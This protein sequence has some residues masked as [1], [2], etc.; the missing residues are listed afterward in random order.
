MSHYKD[1]YA[2]P[3]APQVPIDRPPW[4]PCWKEYNGRAEWWAA[5]GYKHPDIRRGVTNGI[6]PSFEE[7]D[8]RWMDPKVPDGT[9]LTGPQGNDSQYHTPNTMKFFYY[10]K[11]L[12]AS[13][14][15]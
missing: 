11:F 5:L 8:I 1:P 9:S 10:R 2:P 14:N 3:L 12:R 7:G 13:E 6:S 15:D 4:V